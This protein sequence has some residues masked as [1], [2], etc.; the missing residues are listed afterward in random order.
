MALTVLT[1]KQ[2]TEISLAT[3]RSNLAFAVARR[4]DVP[5][6]VRAVFPGVF[7]L[8]IS[9]RFDKSARLLVHVL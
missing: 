4:L 6:D 8:R 9:V 7:D 2:V 5:V 1:D 3:G